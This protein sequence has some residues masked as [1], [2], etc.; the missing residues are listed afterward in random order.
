MSMYTI[1]GETL[2]AE[3]VYESYVG[4]QSVSDFLAGVDDEKIAPHCNAYAR[5]LPSLLSDGT[6]FTERDLDEMADGLFG[7]VAR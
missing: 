4:D 7:Y 5:S 2:T 3:Q 6:T 1:R